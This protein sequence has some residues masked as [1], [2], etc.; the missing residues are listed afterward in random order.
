MGHYL[1]LEAFGTMTKAVCSAFPEASWTPSRTTPLSRAPV[2]RVGQDHGRQ[3]DE[4]CCACQ[5]AQ[6]SDAAFP[7]NDYLKTVHVWHS[8]GDDVVQW[9]AWAQAKPLGPPTSSR[10]GALGA[11]GYKGR[12]EVAKLANKTPAKRLHVRPRTHVQIHPRRLLLRQVD[13]GLSN[14]SVGS[15][16][17]D[18]APIAAQTLSLQVGQ[19]EGMAAPVTASG[20]ATRHGGGKPER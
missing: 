18:P 8:P 20:L 1:H 5:D 6:D 4:R 9:A 14:K 7:Q 13:C 19:N 15:D 10:L 3:D 17:E 2:L 16:K 11:Y 12:P